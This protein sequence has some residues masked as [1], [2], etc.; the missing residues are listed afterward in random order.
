MEVLSSRVLVAPTDLGRSLAWYTDVL[1]L[2]VYREFGAGG[3]RTGVVLFAGN[4][5]IELSGSGG[6]PSE[7]SLWL[8]VP[9]VDAEW[10]RLLAAGVRPVAPP[11][12][13]PWGL[14]EC[15][16]AGP[17]G[18]RIALVEVPADHPMRRRVD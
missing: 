8:Q 17:D 11:A 5:L 15:W 12:D 3:R 10:E 18:E 1:G 4:G 2:H 7:L 9:D 6:A 14:R 13:Q 16:I